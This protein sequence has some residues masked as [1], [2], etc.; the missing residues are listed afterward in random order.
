MRQVELLPVA[1]FVWLS[2][3]CCLPKGMWFG[4]MQGMS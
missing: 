4:M 2:V 3:N 1:L